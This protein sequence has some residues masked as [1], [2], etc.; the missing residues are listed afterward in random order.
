MI[1]SAKFAALA[2]DAYSWSSRL[3]QPS[4]VT[5]QGS[6]HLG[7]RHDE[8]GALSDLV[9]PAAHHYEVSDVVV[10]LATQPLPAYS[11]AAVAPSFESKADEDIARLIAERMGVGEFFEG[12]SRTTS[13]SPGLVMFPRTASHSTLPDEGAIGW[14]RSVDRIQRKPDVPGARRTHAILRRVPNA[15]HRLRPG[16]PGGT[17]AV[18]VL[19]PSCWAWPGS[20]AR[21]AVS[22]VLMS[23]GAPHPP[24]VRG[25]PDDC[26]SSIRNR[27]SVNPVDAETRGT[28][29]GDYVELFN[30]RG[31][32]VTSCSLPRASS[33]GA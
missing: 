21:G 7:H 14:P 15:A 19:L 29:D 28:S 30:S 27:S 3:R 18:A 10:V 8:Y 25:A 5:S 17:R 32:A 16:D 9:L 22:L 13:V 20:A 1:V 2:V 6:M 24:V 4:P 26:V 23:E 12:R 31:H 11:Q 33:P